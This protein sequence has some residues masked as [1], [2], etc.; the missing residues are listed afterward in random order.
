MI[1]GAM[2]NEKSKSI[3]HEVRSGLAMLLGAVDE[4][5]DANSVTKAALREVVPDFRE[6][7]LRHYESAKANAMQ[8]RMSQLLS[9]A[10][11]LDKM[12]RVFDDLRER[13]R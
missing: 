10:G 1:P 2:D 4:A 12:I 5:A 7:F 6:I 8:G 13:T 9:Q 3:S 11:V